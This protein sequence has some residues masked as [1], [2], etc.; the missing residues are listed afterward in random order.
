MGIFIL[1][2][3]NKLANYKQKAKIWKKKHEDFPVQIVSKGYS[4]AS[5]FKHKF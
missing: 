5:N 1:F 4:R 3:P 2:L